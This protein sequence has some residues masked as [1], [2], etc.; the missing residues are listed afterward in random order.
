MVFTALAFRKKQPGASWTC[1]QPLCR[2]QGGGL[3]SRSDWRSGRWGRRPL[4]P[5]AHF[6]SPLDHDDLCQV[7]ASGET[8]SASIR[9][10]ARMEVQRAEDSGTARQHS[11]LREVSLQQKWTGWQPEKRATSDCTCHK[12]ILYLTGSGLGLRT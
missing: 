10:D 12:G 3:T 7:G 11:N 6:P 5:L 1:S 8:H 4:S 9:E 2:P